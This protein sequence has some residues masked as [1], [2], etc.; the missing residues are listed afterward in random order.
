[1]PRSKNLRDETASLNE[2]DH[3]LIESFGGRAAGQHARWAQEDA[4]NPAASASVASARNM[5]ATFELRDNFEAMSS[6][7]M[8]AWLRE[9]HVAA[10]APVWLVCGLAKFGADMNERNK[11][12]NQPIESSRSASQS[13]RGYKKAL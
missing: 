5:A 2:L 11:E 4:A 6:D 3:A 13:L 12:R 7:Q 10:P 9:K 8:W 1:M